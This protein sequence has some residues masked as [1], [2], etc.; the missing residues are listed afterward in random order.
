[1]AG[2]RRRVQD[3][4]G[5][6]L[7]DRRGRSIVGRLEEAGGVLDTLRVEE[8]RLLGR[9]TDDPAVSRGDSRLRCRRVRRTT[10]ASAAGGGGAQDEERDAAR[11]QDADFFFDPPP[12]TLTSSASASLM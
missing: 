8:T 1:M 2:G 12:V 9:L 3:S 7:G 4:R 5:H 11:V 6:H 10:T